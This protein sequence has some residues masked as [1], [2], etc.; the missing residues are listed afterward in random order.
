MQQIYPPPHKGGGAS[1]TDDQG[2]EDEAGKKPP[3][4]S[5]RWA[6]DGTGIAGVQVTEGDQ[7]PGIGQGRWWD[8]PSNPSEPDAMPTV[9]EPETLVLLPGL[10]EKPQVLVGTN[11]KELSFDWLPDSKRVAVAISTRGATHGIGLFRTDETRIAPEGVLSSTGYT[12]APK[13]ISASPDGNWVA[14]EVYRMSSAEDS[15]LI[16]IAVL[17]TDASHAIRISTPADISKLK[18]IVKGDGHKPQWSPDSKRLLYSSPNSTKT[19][20]D[21]WVVGVDGSNPINL[22]KGKGDNFEAAWSPAKR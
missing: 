11:C 17:S 20:N 18:L 2:Q 4:Q 3:I 16:G 15:S 10:T 9:V 6:P 14:F 8:K 22:T 13:N 7:A 1:D 12:V 21:V 19:G 5:F